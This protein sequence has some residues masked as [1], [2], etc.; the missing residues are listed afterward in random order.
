MARLWI[1][2]SLRRRKNEMSLCGGIVLENKEK[3]KDPVVT[4]FKN[5]AMSLEMFVFPVAVRECLDCTQACLAFWHL[6]TWSKN[7]NVDFSGGAAVALPTLQRDR[8]A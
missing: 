7:S 2:R 5:T 8:F 3:K 1:E 6:C 4:M